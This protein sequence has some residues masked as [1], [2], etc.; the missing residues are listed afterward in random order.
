MNSSALGS[1]IQQGKKTR[2]QPIQ[3]I[4]FNKTRKAI[5]F[6]SETDKTRIFWRIKT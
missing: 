3:L 4:C 5:F 6:S 1:Q 2:F